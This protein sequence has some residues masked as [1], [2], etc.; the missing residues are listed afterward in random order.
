[1]EKGYYFGTTIDGKWWK[2]YKKDG[3]F[4]RG[5]GEYWMEETSFCFRK[6]LTKSPMKI[7]F[8]DIVDIKIGKWHAGEWGGGKPIIKIIWKRDDKVLSSGFLVKKNSDEFLKEI[9]KRLLIKDADH[10]DEI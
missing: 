1:M 2:R 6:Y 10:A 3:F 7:Y 5:N 8:K 4:A 9:K